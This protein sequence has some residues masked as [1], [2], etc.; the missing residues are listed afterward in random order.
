MD[1]CKSCSNWRG[2]GRSLCAD[3]V[4]GETQAANEPF[5]M[6]FSHAKTQSAQ[7]GFFAFSASL[8]EI[9]MARAVLACQSRVRG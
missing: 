2:K 6:V 1:A 7:K 3:G 5:G 9:F 4:K 8:R